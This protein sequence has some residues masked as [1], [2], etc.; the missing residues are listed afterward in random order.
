MIPTN[1]YEHIYSDLLGEGSPLNTHAQVGLTQKLPRFDPPHI[2]TSTSCSDTLYER[3]SPHPNFSQLPGMDAAASTITTKR[4]SDILQ[5]EDPYAWLEN[6]LF[7]STEKPTTSSTPPKRQQVDPPHSNIYTSHCRDWK[8]QRIPSIHEKKSLTRSKYKP[9]TFSPVDV[10]HLKLV[11]SGKLPPNAPLSNGDTPLM[12]YTR[13]KNLNSSEKCQHIKDLM[14]LD[15]DP[16]IANKNGVTP[17]ELSLER[18]WTDIS[19]T[20]LSFKPPL[21]PSLLLFSCLHSK[22]VDFLERLVKFGAKVDFIKEGSSLFAS[23]LEKNL[24]D[25]ERMLVFEKL[26]AVN[27]P[28]IVTRIFIEGGFKNRPLLLHLAI[29]ATRAPEIFDFLLQKAK[30]EALTMP[31]VASELCQIAASSR[32]EL[33]EFACEL[34]TLYKSLFRTYSF[35]IFLTILTSNL[36]LTEVKKK[37]L[38]TKILET[39]FSDDPN[40]KFDINTLSVYDNTSNSQ[41]RRTLL[42]F[43]IDDINLK[44]EEKIPLAQFLIDKGIDPTIKDSNED[45]AITY[46]NKKYNSI[47]VDFLEHILNIEPTNEPRKLKRKAAFQPRALTAKHI[48]N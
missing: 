39:Q 27:T 33:F 7:A 45:D 2:D 46:A 44:P 18:G 17:L 32:L 9:T 23:F 6:N 20:L 40:L 22:S 19:N 48:R 21:N 4:S 10:A 41:T 26:L 43:L 34:M 47:M 35:K 14:N 24:R 37:E 5:I 29:S 28:Q 38:L 11:M 13:N 16:N 3:V 36:G 8:N 1:P 25:R 15:A 12:A 42:G 31:S 30:V